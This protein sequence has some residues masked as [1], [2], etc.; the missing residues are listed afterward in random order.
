ME[1][2]AVRSGPFVEDSPNCV[3]VRYQQLADDAPDSEFQKEGGRP[4]IVENELPRWYVERVRL[5]ERPPQKGQVFRPAVED[6]MDRVQQ[7]V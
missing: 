7:E 4:E 3:P 5:E 1:S 2:E 6:D